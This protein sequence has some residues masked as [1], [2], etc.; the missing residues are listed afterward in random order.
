MKKIIEVIKTNKKGI[1]KKA[2]I[3]GGSAAVLALAYGK[4]QRDNNESNEDFDE[5]NLEN[6]EVTEQEA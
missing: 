2:L 6:E 3:I 4:M 5:N 1:I